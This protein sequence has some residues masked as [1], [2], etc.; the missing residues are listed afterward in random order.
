M[1]FPE[2]DRSVNPISNR[3]GADY[4]HHQWSTESGN[5]RPKQKIFTIWL[6]ASA[7]EVLF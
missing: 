5:I 4:A 1:T 7:D 6:S 2:L 3:G